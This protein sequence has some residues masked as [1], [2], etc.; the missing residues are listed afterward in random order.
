M[1]VLIHIS[2]QLSNSTTPAFEPTA[3]QVSS[4]A[5][6]VNML[7]FL[8]LALVLID[9]FLAML[10][11]GWL[12][13]FDRGW[14]KFTVAHLRAQERERRL[15]ELERWKMHELVALLPILLQGSLL[16]FCIGLL[17]LI[18]P[19]HLPSGILSSI[20]FVSIVGFYGFTTY[21]SIVN[22]YAP[23]SSPASRLLA[24]GLAMLRVW[25][26][27]NSQRFSSAISFHNRPPLPPQGQQADINGSDETTQPPFSNIGVTNPAQPHNPDSVEKSNIEPSSHSGI[28]SKTH[29]HILERL[30]ATTDE[31]V[32]NIPIFLELLDQ[33]VKD[34]TLR[35]L[36][37]E[38]WKELLRITFR[39]L[40]D[41]STI[42]VSAACT[43]ARTMMMCY[44]HETH[45]EQM[46]LTLRHHLGSRGADNRGARIPLSVLFFAYLPYWVR[47]SSP[48]DLWRAIA[49]LEP[50]D[51]ADA[52]LLWMVNTF[53]RTMQYTGDFW[54]D[55]TLDVESRLDTYLGFFAA[56]LTYVSSTEQSRRSKVPLTAAVIYALHTIRSAIDKGGID[57]ITGVYILPG[58][59]STA[60]SVLMTFCHVD[61]IDVLDLWSEQCIQFVKDI[62]RWDWPPNLLNDFQLSLIAALYIDCTKQAHTR[63]TLDDLL[64]HT[65]IAEINFEFSNA[66]D[67][68]KLAVYLYVAL[69]QNTPERDRDTIYCVIEDTINKHSTLRLSALHILEIAAQHIHKT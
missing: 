23:F 19:L 59:V 15:Q 28:D 63:D 35:P 54:F 29:V 65:R 60:E 31:A 62:F 47:Y 44:D 41:Q 6:A 5:V 58:S 38:K 18:F 40:R 13:E 16:L 49:L 12:Q 52:E 2:Q 48:S 55:F 7:F 45:D 51:A 30:V 1:D 56:V 25:Y 36:N 9:A 11:K 21:V 68:G 32:E 34:L 17:V 46:Y 33:P 22:N 20:L 27:H 64:K 39:L 37:V 4:N 69:S 61:G 26:N 42:S 66:Y 57:S 3:F 24:R 50:S 10:I 8:S 43:L 14:R 53:H 67:G